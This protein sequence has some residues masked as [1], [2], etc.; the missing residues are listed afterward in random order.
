MI[1]KNVSNKLITL[2]LRNMVYNKIDKLKKK[3]QQIFEF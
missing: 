2:R 1:K 3:Q